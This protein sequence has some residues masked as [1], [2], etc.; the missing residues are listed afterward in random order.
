[1]RNLKVSP[2]LPRSLCDSGNFGTTLKTQVQ[3][4]L[5]R[6]LALRGHVTNASNDQWAVILLL[7]KLDRT[8]KNDLTPEIWE[9]THLREIFYVALI[10][11]RSSMI[12]IDRHVGGH[13]LALQHG[14]VTS[15][16]LSHFKQMVR[17]WKTKALLFCLRDDPRIVFRRQNHVTFIFIKTMS[18]DLLV[19]VAYLPRL[20]V[21][22]CLSHKGHNFWGIFSVGFHETGRHCCK[23]RK[24]SAITLRCQTANN[25]SASSNHA[26][27]ITKSALVIKKE[28]P[29]SANQH[30][31]ILW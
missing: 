14:G 17:V 12:C 8:H 9:E 15:N 7:P 6:P 24:S 29:V 27:L 20:R 1:M 21:I 10:F 19:Q 5:N 22:T 31:V 4:I 25:Q 16:G 11:Q 3:V 2:K 26:L 30:S 13:A 18:H 23:K 28:C